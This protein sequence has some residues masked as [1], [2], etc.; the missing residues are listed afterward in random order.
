MKGLIVIVGAVLVCGCHERK[1]LQL[2]PK[3]GTITWTPSASFADLCRR[4]DG[5]YGRPPELHAPAGHPP[6]KIVIGANEWTVHYTTVAAL[7]RRSAWAFED[8]GHHR[9]WLPARTKEKEAQ[10]LL[11]HEILHATLA[12]SRDAVM[13]EKPTYG[14]DEN[15]FIAP[16]TPFLLEVLRDNPE[17][18]EWLRRGR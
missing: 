13:G 3:E 1:P 7:D 6:L 5:E 17:L 11:L 18:V 9:I 10:E 12:E 2:P 8:A 4:L 16:M 14:P 15:S